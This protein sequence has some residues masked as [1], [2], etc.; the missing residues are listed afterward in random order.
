MHYD[1]KLAREEYLTRISSSIETQELD[2]NILDLISLLVFYYDLSSFKKKKEKQKL[3][4]NWNIAQI[5]WANFCAQ[6]LF[7]IWYTE[8]V[9]V[10]I[11]DDDDDND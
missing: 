5:S 2:M 8:Q 1:F 3:L 11:Q 4:E 7:C 6:T 9:V 10:V